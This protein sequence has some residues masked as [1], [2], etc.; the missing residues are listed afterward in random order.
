MALQHRRSTLVHFVFQRLNDVWMV[1]PRVVNAVVRQKVQNATAVFREQLAAQTAVIL[2]VHAQ[3][4]QQS[5][6]LRI[7]VFMVVGGG[8]RH[9]G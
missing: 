9:T 4:V 7:N 6:P 1:V 8:R 5:D 2:D 3:Q